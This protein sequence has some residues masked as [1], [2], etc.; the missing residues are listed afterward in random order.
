MSDPN[1]HRPTPG[2][3]G[4]LLEQ[5]QLL[6][7]LVDSVKEYA[8]FMLDPAGHVLTWNPG[9]ERIKG[10]PAREI[11][12]R[13]FAVFFTPEDVRRGKPEAELRE[14]AEQGSS[15]DEGWRVRRDGT[16]FFASVVVTALR[17]PDGALRGF[18]KITRDL[19]ERR[20][21]EEARRNLAEAREA[22]RS[23]DDFLAVASH[24]LRTPLTCVQLVTQSLARQTHEG[25]PVTVQQVERLEQLQRHVAR[26]G[27]LV[28]GLLDLAEMSR[29]A[30][31]LEPAPFDLS[32]LV[33]EVAARFEPDVRRKGAALS[34]HAP[35]PIPGRWDRRRVGD[36]IAAVL[37]N[38]VKYGGRSPIEI[39][40]SRDDGR[41]VVVIEDRGPGIA[42]EDQSR[43][44]ERFERAAPVAHYPGLGVGLWTAR[45]ILNAHG[46]EI[47]VESA[48]GKGARFSLR[49]PLESPA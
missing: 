31:Q 48:A 32:E 47:A 42:V 37:G 17:G 44:F 49:L 11:V 35:G 40:A 12:G 22:V 25:Q 38:A 28:S 27:D 30:L 34:V 36:A 3:P 8:I 14:A 33:Q 26:L 9:A 41:A 20:R 43:V 39:T 10:Y 24:E 2:G 29:G 45:Q 7:L 23:R 15:E 21:G 18:A 19:T 16:R 1:D 13:H 6:R 4:H 46:G 5:E